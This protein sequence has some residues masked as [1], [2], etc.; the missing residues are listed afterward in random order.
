ML[1]CG[2][3]RQ[4]GL[5]D[6]GRPRFVAQGAL[7]DWY[8]QQVAVHSSTQRD[9]ISSCAVLPHSREGDPGKGCLQRS[10]AGEAGDV[11]PYAYLSSAAAALLPCLPKGG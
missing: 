1:A 3:I 2:L 5:V 4:C 7:C 11:G 8:G 6:C 10:G 9:P